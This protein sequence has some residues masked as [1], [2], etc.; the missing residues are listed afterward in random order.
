MQR[1]VYS[2]QKQVSQGI[3]PVK[4]FYFG[5]FL[6]LQTQ[7]VLAYC[8]QNTAFPDPEYQKCIEV[9]YQWALLGNSGIGTNRYSSLEALVAAYNSF[10]GARFESC[11]AAI[12][13]ECQSVRIDGIGGPHQLSILING[14]ENMITLYQTGLIHNVNSEGQVTADYSY[15]LG[16]P[17][18]TLLTKCPTNWGKSHVPLSERSYNDFCTLNIQHVVVPTPQP[19]PCT[20]SGSDPEG[21]PCNPASGAKT[22]SEVDYRAASDI[23][24]LHLTRYYHSQDKTQYSGGLGD[25]WRH[26]YASIL[27][28]SPVN[29]DVALYGSSRYSTSTLACTNGINDL[30]VTAWGGT[31]N[32]AV[33]A[34]IN[35]NT[36]QISN[37]SGQAQAEFSIAQVPFSGN[38]GVAPP[39]E[40]YKTLVRGDGTVYQFKL[41]NGEWRSEFSPNVSL[42]QS[43]SYWFFTRG[44]GDQEIYNERGHLISITESQGATTNLYHDIPISE[45]G[46]SNPDTLD[47]VTDNL[48]HNLIFEYGITNGITRL[49]RVTTPA[50][51]IDYRYDGSGNLEYV[52]NADGTT[53]QYHYDDPNFASALTGITDERGIRYATWEY[54]A[55]G[56]ATLSEHAGGVERVNLTYNSDKTTTVT[57]SRGARRTYHFTLQRGKLDVTQITGDQCTR[58]PNGD[59]KDRRY[60]TSGDL[61]SHTDWGDVT[62]RLGNYDTKRQYG[63]KV[64]GITAADTSDNSTASCNFDPAASPDA[65]RTDYTYDTRFYNKITSITEP[66]VAPG[67]SKI[68]T[69]S[70]DDWGN[71]LSETITGHRPDGTPVSRTTAYRYDGP[72]HQLSEIDGPRTDVA[73]IT[74]YDYYPNDASQDSNRARLLRVTDANGVNLRDNIQYSATGKVLSESRPNGLT[75]LYTYYAGNDRLETLTENDA[76]STRVTR[77]TYL[78]TGEVASI[79]QGDGTADETRLSFGYDDARRLTRL[80]DGRGNYI[81]Y[82]LDTEGNREAE[83]I[84]DN[85]GTLTKQLTQTFDLY[86]RLDTTAQMNEQTDPDFAPDGTLDRSTDGRGAVTDYSYDAL[87]RLTQVMQDQNGSDPGT[88][89]ATTG[90]GYDVADHLTR[91]TDPINGTT[92]YAYDD[93]GNLLTQTS[94]DTGT[95]TFTYDSAGNLAS[96]TDAKG[97]LFSYSYDALNRLILIDGPGTLDFSYAYDSCANGSGRLCS[98]TG[99]NATVSYRYS[100]FGEVAG[101]DQTV[102]TWTGLHSAAT[103]LDYSYDSAGRLR[104]LRYPSG[105]TV[106]YH[107]SL[108]GV[109]RGIDLERP[110]NA[111]VNLFHVSS[112][113]PFGPVLYGTFGNG[114]PLYQFVD[115]AYR[116]NWRYSGPYQQ[117]INPYSNAYDGNGNLLGWTGTDNPQF[118]YDALDRLDSASATSFGNRDYAYDRNGN[119]SQLIAD[120]VTTNY[121][122]SAQSNRMSSLA[123]QSVTL[124][125]NGNTTA[126]RDMTFSY[127]ANNRM[128]SSLRNGQTLAQY[129]YNGLGQR[130]LKNRTVVNGQGPKRVFAYGQDGELLVETGSTG[131]V[132]REYVYLD[133]QPL[134]V[135]DQVPVSGEAFLRGDFDGDGVITGEDFYEWYFLHYMTGPD[136]AYDVTGDGVN[137][138]TDYNTMVGCAF[139]GQNCRASQYES[140]LYYVHNDHLGTPKAM[141]DGTGNT[142]WSVTHDPFGKATV[143]ASSSVEM[144]VRLPGQYYDQ[145]T[146]LH[147]NYFRTYDPGTGRY[148]ESDPIGLAGGLNSYGYV[149]SSPIRFHDETGLKKSDLFGPIRWLLEHTLSDHGMDWLQHQD[150]LKLE[151]IDELFDELRNNTDYLDAYNDKGLSNERINRELECHRRYG[152][153]CP[154]MPIELQRCLKDVWS[155]YQRRRDYY[156]E[157]NRKIRDTLRDLGVR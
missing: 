155:D 71:R 14:S 45:G 124:D 128:I 20:G 110:G 61:I 33:A 101:I 60:N 19:N 58:C 66:S 62:T 63:C 78:P 142:V 79:T 149:G 91:V 67:Q 74:T 143:A 83:R 41:I 90:Y 133:G 16:D 54:N 72:L 2:Q 30:R 100:G 29:N 109:V 130:V 122:Y 154:P 151:R 26:N 25:H 46:D 70:Y 145:E 116:A 96:K 131:Q 81:E 32:H 118:S 148:L 138:Q 108:A 97:Q 123:G 75:L 112:R 31:L 140:R 17:A 51:E 1:I 80:T 104:S 92:T 105:A 106:T 37:T 57:D 120:G 125:A 98:V 150:K 27:K 9:E 107:Y 94:P 156:S 5:L 23:S 103:A 93:L 119:R 59:K 114:Q 136:P 99:P 39:H 127:N 3:L 77:W 55:D 115:Q 36:C 4:L 157:R 135:L 12:P 40:N 146:G 152:G 10:Y 65:R 7:A 82:Q 56:K 35:L 69:Y 64:E 15:D 8:P 52:D 24:N 38:P 86:N 144:N 153:D 47:R 13:H 42:V 117:W 102:T 68:T 141:T 53:R 132:T 147:Y 84:Y 129:R 49:T 50:G 126:L 85:S 87:K 22:Q 11:K 89:N 76:S 121:A 139:G 48:G 43:G 44:R 88:A 34:R 28:S 113:H 134:A 73:D 21:N 137:N 111:P 6:L 18:A 95:T